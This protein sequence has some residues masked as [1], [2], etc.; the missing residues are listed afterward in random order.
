MR[1]WIGLALSCAFSLLAAE[2]SA[3]GGAAGP[4]ARVLP[5]DFFD[6]WGARRFA[7]Y[8]ATAIRELHEGL[9]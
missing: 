4:L 2:V 6:Q 3:Q 9:P 8:A 7:R 5:F 1:F